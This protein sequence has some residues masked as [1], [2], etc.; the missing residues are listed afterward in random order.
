MRH[1]YQIRFGFTFGLLF[2]SLVIALT[3]IELLLAAASPID[4]K[5]LTK[6]IVAPIRNT[7]L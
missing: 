1:F 2:I 3:A 6:E 5:P 7:T 4:L